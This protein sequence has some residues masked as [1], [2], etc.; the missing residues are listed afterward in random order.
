MDRD[1]A[2]LVPPYIDTRLKLWIIPIR[3]FTYLLP[4]IALAGTAWWGAATD[5]TALF[6]GAAATALFAGVAAIALVLGTH[7]YTTPADRLA[8]IRKHFANRRLY[9]WS[10]DDVVDETVHGVRRIYSDGTAEMED[11]RMVGLVRVGGRNTDQQSE[12]EANLMVGQL[13][14]GIDEDIQDFD[15]RFW[16]STTEFDPERVGAKYREQAFSETFADEEWAPAREVLH[17]IAEWAEDVDAPRWRARDWQHYIVVEVAPEEVD[18]PARDDGVESRGQ[19]LLQALTPGDNTG[20][21]ERSRRRGELYERL[22]TVEEDVLGNVQ[23]VDGERIGAGEHALLLA[24]YWTGVGHELDPEAVDEEVDVAVFPWVGD[25]GAPVDPTQR[26]SAVEAEPETDPDAVVGEERVESPEEA[27]DEPEDEQ[28]G[29]LRRVRD[30]LVGPAHGGA[31][32]PE[33]DTMAEALSPETYDVCDGHTRVGEQYC[34]T[35]WVASWPTEPGARFL[36]ELYTMRDVDLDVC[37]R[38]RSRDK[39]STVNELEHRIAEVDASAL[40]REEDTDIS[41]M[42]ADDTLESLVKMY[43]IVR[44]TNSQPWD[45]AGYV[46]V[47][48]GTRRA[49]ERAEQEID[50]GLATEDELTLDVAKRRALEDDVERVRDRLESAPA[51]LL[52]LSPETRQGELFAAASPTGRDEYD[53]IST[54]D[55]YTLTLG[56][57]LGAA[58]PFCAA[59]IDEDGGVEFGR[60]IQN[61]SEV[62]ADPF[63]RGGAPHLLTIA[64]SGSGKTYSVGKRALRWWLADPDRTLILCDTMG[65]FGGVTE[66]A[67]GERFVV[68]GTQ[69]INPLDIRET[70][71]AVLDGADIDPYRMKVDEAR[72]FIAG[73]LRSQGIDPGPF[74]ATI[75]EALEATYARAGIERDDPATHGRTSPTMDEFLETLGDMLENPTDYTH[76]DHDQ[77]VEEKEKAASRLLD[78]LSGF[79]EHGKYSHLVGQS[80]A[81]ITPGSVT[82]LDLQQIEGQGAAEK[83]TMLHLILGQVYQAVKQAP[84]KTMFVVDEAHYLLYSE[85]MIDWLQRAARHWRHYE[86][87]MWF[88]SQSP[89]EFVGGAGDEASEHRETIL[90]QCSTVEF[91]RTPNLSQDV[92]QRFGM[93]ASQREF[94]R[95]RATPGSAGLGYSQGMV[96]FEDMSGW[97]RLQVAASPLEDAVLTYDP[98][99]DGPFREYLSGHAGVDFAPRGGGEAASSGVE[100]GVRASKNGTQNGEGGDIE[101]IRGIGPT[102]SDR[103]RE[104]GITTVEE[105]ADVEPVTVADAADVPV[106]R[107]KEWAARASRNGTAEVAD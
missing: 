91:Y 106:D 59:T 105:L 66:L 22:A 96:S 57:T 64:K 42:A 47:R 83:S 10:H 41:A 6:A 51:D 39:R 56:G 90:G 53:A 11:G 74:V 82:Y 35:F 62:I 86:A 107:A 44:Q 94:V 80:D 89:Q 32:L 15:F 5:R 104:A 4:A 24:R 37:L 92:G 101:A 8:T 70:P 40:E 84:E 79:K 36:R 75:E 69:T 48:A 27:F 23:G 19:R 3:E 29:L 63:K 87:A 71:D 85:E 12:S 18:A 17:G 95:S 45:L 52:V 20:E 93:N 65:G 61:G 98:D 14:D 76:T 34:R 58:F 88:V 30:A 31:V 81:R 1:P 38:A 25:D 100:A 43:E 7:E 21:Q 50:D 13:S 2:Q 72:E 73:I 78:K 60:S 26:P 16:S 55:R 9:P 102:Y 68:D 33:G 103:L 49:L 77:E 28:A 99:S 54:R 97:L 46:T 67:N